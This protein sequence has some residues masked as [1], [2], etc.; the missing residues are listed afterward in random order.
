MNIYS[1]NTIKV[2]RSIIHFKK[3]LIFL[4]DECSQ[5]AF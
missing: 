4:S 2:V 3:V 1:S 5:W